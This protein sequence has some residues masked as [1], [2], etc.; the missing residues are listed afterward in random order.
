MLGKLEV[1]EIAAREVGL[2]NLVLGKL[3]WGNDLT[4]LFSFRAF[5][6]NLCDFRLLHPRARSG[7]VTQCPNLNYFQKK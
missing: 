4:P 1:G 7:C 5:L 6:N 2:G 3:R